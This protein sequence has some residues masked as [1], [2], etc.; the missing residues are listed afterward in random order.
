MHIYQLIRYSRVFMSHLDVFVQNV[1]NNNKPTNQW[2]KNHLYFT[3]IVW[4]EFW[5]L[6][7]SWHP[8]S[9]TFKY[10]VFLYS[11]LLLTKG[12]RDYW[13]LSII[14]IIILISF[15]HIYWSTSLDTCSIKFIIS[16][17]CPE[18]AEE[19]F[20]LAH[21]MRIALFITQP[22]YYLKYF[23]LEYMKSATDY[24]IS[25]SFILFSFIWAF[26]RM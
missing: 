11:I 26:I 25:V 1:G 9:I 18:E 21:K 8:L 6:F 14:D 12:K 24:I 4:T 16:S 10:E 5:P 3:I 23:D 17:Q 13:Q 22:K 20:L 2:I 15:S 19:D 7:K